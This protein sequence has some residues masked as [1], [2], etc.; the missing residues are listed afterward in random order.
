MAVRF[1]VQQ[2]R[3]VGFLHRQPDLMLRLRL[4]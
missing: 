2:G 4:A 1:E 3:F